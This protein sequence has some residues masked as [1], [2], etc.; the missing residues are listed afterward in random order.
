[1]TRADR[2]IIAVIAALALVAW[3]LMSAT[4]GSESAS[5]V[6]SGPN[7]QTVVPL[8]SDAEYRIAGAVSDL[9]VRVEGGS[10]RVVESDCPDRTCV[11][12]GAIS[13]PGDVVACVPNRVVV[14]IG[15]E[16]ADEFDA[17]IR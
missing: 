14:R 16:H 1:M 2:L 6:I 5:V 11:R 15:G 12:T 4:A 13:A 3:P 7:G 10:V 9:V 17:R 8:S